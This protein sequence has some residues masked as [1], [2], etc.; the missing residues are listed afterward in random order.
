VNHSGTNHALFENENGCYVNTETWSVPDVASA[1]DLPYIWY[2]ESNGEDNTFYIK[3]FVSGNYV[4]FVASTSKVIPTITEATY[5]YTIYQFPGLDINWVALDGGTYCLHHTTNGTNRVQYWDTSHKNSAW[6]LTKIPQE[7]IDNLQE[8]L[9]QQQRNEKLNELYQ[10]ANEFYKSGFAYSSD[11]TDDCDFSAVDGLVT[12]V[13]QLSTNAQEPTEGPIDNLLDA[14]ET[15]FFHTAW[16]TATG[17]TYHNMTSHFNKS[18]EAVTLKYCGRYGSYTGVTN[19]RPKKVHIY[20]SNDA[21]T[22]TD[23]GYVTFSYYNTSSD[24]T[25]ENFGGLVTATFDGSYEYMQMDVEENMGSARSSSGELYFF[26]GE[27]RAYEATYDPDNSIVERVDADIRKEFENALN[28]AYNAIQNGTA[29]DEDY[30]TLKA[31]YEKYKENYPDASLL[32]DLIEEYQK[33]LDSAEEDAEA[34]GYYQDGSKTDFQDVIDE[35]S[36]NLEDMTTIDAI[37]D[38]R[39]SLE[40]A[41]AEFLSKLNCPESG[42]VYYM[43]EITNGS[44]AYVLNNDYAGT[45]AEM[46]GSADANVINRLIMMWKVVKQ[47][48]GTFAFQ[49]LGTGLYLENPLAEGNYYV[50]QRDP[51]KSDSISWT[52]KSSDQAGS[53]YVQSTGDY[54]LTNY[55]NSGNLITY[56]NTG[57]YSR[58]EFIEVDDWGGSAYVDA[59]A[60]APTAF[61][62]P[63]PIYSDL[64]DDGDICSVIGVRRTSEGDYLELKTY[65]DG[66]V[67][68][69]GTPFVVMAGSGIEGINFVPAFDDLTAIQHVLTPGTNGGLYGALAPVTLSA[70]QGKFTAGTNLLSIAADGDETEPNSA[71]V[72]NSETSDTEEV[73]D[74]SI[75]IDGE[76]GEFLTGIRDILVNGVP[77]SGKTFDLQGRRVAKPANGVFIVNGQKV[78]VK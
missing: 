55:T 58:F 37:K 61:T 73:G 44:Y 76:T 57:T 78:F 12:E 50:M 21:Q 43:K 74:Y 66:V 70:G 1:D 75:P 2:L 62:L 8:A 46:G 54:I 19:G 71:Y 25:I 23:Q 35:V 49:N 26:L 7:Q 53:F 45:R 42:K 34:L 27:Y 60:D 59:T 31:A 36:A 39:E 69:A 68:E 18:V 11:A 38:A 72:V 47:D 4:G 20:T 33:L 77:Q 52:L 22:W 17:T 40:N 29:T 6:Q 30:E 65:D 10:E 9:E 32:T 48:D 41:Y 14:D 64:G 13:S 51:E 56:A 28:Q 5:P 63:Y 24:G 15:T 16:S 67:I 3:N